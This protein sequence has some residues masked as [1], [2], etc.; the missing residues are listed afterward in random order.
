MVISEFAVA[1]ASKSVHG[2][3]KFCQLSINSVELVDAVVVFVAVSL[4]E[5]PSPTTGVEELSP[6]VILE[7]VE[8]EAAPLEPLPEAE[9]QYESSS[10][11][12]SSQFQSN[13]L[14]SVVM[15]RYCAD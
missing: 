14:Y 12:S 7:S 15:F 9:A 2:K 10:V 13:G 1:L 6:V 11:I 5:P 8:F 3:S 4:P